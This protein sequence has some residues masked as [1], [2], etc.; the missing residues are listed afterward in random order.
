MERRRKQRTRHHKPSSRTSI[1]SPARNSVLRLERAT[2]RPSTSPPPLPTQTHKLTI[3]K[4]QGHVAPKVYF[5][6]TVHI[7]RKGYS[8]YHLSKYSEDYLVSM[9]KI[10]IEGLMTGSLSPELS[11]TSYIRSSSGYTIKIEY[12]SKGWIHGK[13]NGFTATLVHDSDP[14]A[15]LY[16]VEGVWSEGWTVREGAGGKGKVVEKF[17][18]DAAPRMQLHVRPVEEQHPLESRRAWRRVVDA[19]HRG[20]IFGVGHEKTKIENE[21]REMRKRE[22]QDGSEFP[23]RYFSRAAEDKVAEKLAEGM[24]DTSMKGE[25]DVQHGI[26]T[27]DEEKY[28]RL[29]KSGNEGCYVVKSPTRKR[30]DSGVGGIIID[31]AGSDS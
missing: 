12:S 7:D 24:G 5:S 31:E 22:R 16:T 3:P 25:M 23:R 17:E 13:R 9:P 11:G 8:L 28:R 20:D 10:H 21:Q 1:P 18:V 26:W 4:L 29:H 27:W 19:I 14:K 6:S 15:V 30:F 2:R